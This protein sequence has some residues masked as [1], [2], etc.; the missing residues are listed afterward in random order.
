MTR[1][2]E[3]PWASELGVMLS[4]DEGKGLT[5]KVNG[6]EVPEGVTTVTI[7]LPGGA[8]AAMLTAA[9][10]LPGEEAIFVTVIPSGGAKLTAVAPF[11]FEPEIVNS[12]VSRC[13]ALP[14]VTVS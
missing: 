13:R 9:V 10:I 6:F 8:S 2:A 11:R 3:D 4:I 1:K 12:R 7:R 14:G 5:V